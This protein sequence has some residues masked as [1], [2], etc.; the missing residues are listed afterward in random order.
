MNYNYK[1]LK[2]KNKYNQL[3]KF[4]YK[5]SFNVFIGGDKISN[6]INNNENDILNVIEDNIISNANNKLTIELFDNFDGASNLFSPL[7]VIFALSILQ[8]GALGETNNQLSRIFDHKYNL[9]ELQYI[10]QL[11]YKNVIRMSNYILI[12]KINKINDEYIGMIKNISNIMIDDFTNGA[13]I[14]YKVNNDIENV[15]DGMIKNIISEDEIHNSMSLIII[16]STYFKASWKLKFD[17][18]LTSKM[19]FHRTSTNMVDMMYQRN[20]FNYYENNSIQ[21]IELPYDENDYVMG[22]I[23]PKHI[24]QEIDLDYSINNIPRFTISEINEFINNLQFT[25]IDIFIPK[26]I[27]KKRFDMTPLI[28]K[29]GITDIF[30]PNKAELDILNKNVY[31]SKII[32]E[33][34]IIVDEVGI[35]APTKKN[36]SKLSTQKN[37]EDYENKPKVFMANHAFIYYIRHYPSN[38]ILFYGDYQGN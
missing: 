23:L 17:V 5:N 9:D 4:F 3:K 12:N 34:L 19:K 21:M 11:L 16:N 27:E 1:Y 8:L 32:H 35:E 30:D 37:G 28:Q 13:L 25:N 10:H 33:T 24:Y 26:F 6:E 18:N 36:Y 14:S 31:L 22:I 2:Y 20:Y 15:T 7:S 29:M 38:I